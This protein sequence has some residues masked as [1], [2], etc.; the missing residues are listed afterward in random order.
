[1]QLIQSPEGAPSF[2]FGAYKNDG[3]CVRFVQSD[4]DYPDLV[5]FLGGTPPDPDVVGVSTSLARSFDWLEQH[6]LFW[7]NVDGDFLDA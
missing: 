1:L 7:F 5:R 6:D 2:C 4:W 3:E